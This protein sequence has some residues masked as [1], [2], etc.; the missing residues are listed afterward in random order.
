VSG[1]ESARSGSVVALPAPFPWARP[2]SDRVATGVAHAGSSG[3]GVTVALGVTG[4]VSPGVAELFV[5]VRVRSVTAYG[6]APPNVHCGAI[7]TRHDAESTSAWPQS[8]VGRA[9]PGLDPLAGGASC[10][11]RAAGRCTGRV[12]ERVCDPLPCG[13][14]RPGGRDRGR[15]GAAATAGSLIPDTRK[16]PGLACRPCRGARG[17]ESLDRRSRVQLYPAVSRSTTHDTRR[18]VTCSRRAQLRMNACA[19]F[20]QFWNCGCRLLP[21]G[22]LDEMS[23]CA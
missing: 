11:L 20:Y 10:V 3:D 8:A 1:R 4:G 23:A 14:S 16:P 17:F 2:R 9:Q 5:A 15:G 6:V 18:V 19:Y 21:R 22:G 7:G 13:G 12:S